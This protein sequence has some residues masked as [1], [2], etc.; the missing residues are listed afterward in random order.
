[1]ARQT[2]RLNQRGIEAIAKGAEMRALVE[3]AAE[4]IARNVRAQGIKV[5]DRDGGPLEYELPVKVK[6]TTTDRAHASVILAHP[7]GIAVQAKHGALTRAAASAG[8][9]V[10]GE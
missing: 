1:M 10:S 2:I 6:V 3:K 7:A 4:E 5:G 9:E 8:L